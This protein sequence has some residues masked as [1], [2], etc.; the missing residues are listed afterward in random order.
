MGWE[1]INSQ[2]SMLLSNT[3]SVI[4][5]L[6]TGI[7]QNLCGFAHARAKL[8]TLF[9]PLLKVRRKAWQMTPWIIQLHKRQFSNTH[10][11]FP[12]GIFITAQQRLAM[13]QAFYPSSVKTY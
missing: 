4:C 2:P 1:A 13:F 7:P 12:A 8:L 6:P 10:A 5:T 9:S 11:K 3:N